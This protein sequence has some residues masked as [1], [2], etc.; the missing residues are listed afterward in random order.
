MVRVAS[1]QTN[2]QA[3]VAENLRALGPW[4]AGAADAGADVVLLPEGFAFLG[5]EVE[6]ARHAES[7]DAPGPIV[8]F[9][10]A[11][12]AKY[13]VDLIAGGLP[14]KSPDPA[15]PY[16]TSLVVRRDGSLAESYRKIH[17]F[18]VDLADG[19]RLTESAGNSPGDE[20]VVASLGGFG[21]GLAI[22]YDLRFPEL[23]AR[24][25][26]SGAEVLTLPAAFTATTGAAHWH[27]LLR[28]RA[29]ETQC[30]VVAAAQVGEHPRGRRTFGH[31]LIV[32]PWGAILAEKNEGTGVIVA[33]LSR[34]ELE[35]VRARMPLERH[36]RL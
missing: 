16:N 9:L 26:K 35:D 20:T 15:R 5:D 29:I 17:L 27:A 21:F 34:P 2:S 4:I 8:E 36:R 10:R 11:H 28:A 1:V 24:E 31:S 22:C 30:Y 19:T 14:E 7:L 32:D 25:R 6:K 33:E 18:D 3:D 13:H 12:A 23:F